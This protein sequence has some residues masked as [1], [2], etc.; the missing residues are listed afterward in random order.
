[1]EIIRENGNRG[2]TFVVDADIRSYFDSIDQRK[3]MMLVERRICDRRVLKLLR[4]WLEAGVLEDGS[5]RETLAGTP[6]GGVISPLLANVYLHVLDRLWEDQ[7]GHLGVLVRY[8]D[9][10]VV[11][12]RSESA[13]KAALERIKVILARLG[14]ELHPKKT[15]LVDL[16][17]GRGKFEFLGFTLLKQRSIQRR[18]DRHF[19]Q[20]WPSPRAMKRIRERVHQLTQVRGNGARD[21][22]EVIALLNP[23]LR[24]W[25]NYFRNGNSDRKFQQIDHYVRA[26]IVRWLLRRAG[27]RPGC[28][29]RH[30]SSSRLH[31]LGLHRLSRTV[32]Y[33]AQAAPRRS[34]V[35]RVPENGT[36]G[37]KGGP[38]LP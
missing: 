33:A 6:Q 3:L 1:L 4:Q 25:A 8:A 20:R 22:Q 9:D 27:H 16:R 14:L 21:V 38:A 32:R 30:W 18:P 29:V 11:L 34:S 17:Y 15:R 5:I 37:L 24:G 13:A 35:S 19:M 12:C 7:V 28:R 2:Y 26:R 23:A 10:F 31:A 36:H